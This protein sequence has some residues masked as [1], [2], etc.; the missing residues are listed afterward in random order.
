M[1]VVKKP[2]TKIN[3]KKFTYNTLWTEYGIAFGKLFSPALREEI[4]IIG[5][6]K[7]NK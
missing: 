5:A 1:Y 7:K 3:I 4:C 2:T 6:I